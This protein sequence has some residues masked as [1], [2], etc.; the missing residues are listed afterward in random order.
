M[1]KLSVLI[2]LVLALGLIY[3]CGEKK[4]EAAA[5]K[6]VET[7]MVKDVVCNMDVDPSKSTVTAEYEGKKYYF[8]AEDCKVKFEANPAQ[9]VMASEGEHDHD[10][11]EGA[12]HK[13]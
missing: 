13:H 12:D 7:K 3:G 9:Y 10:H 2:I 8:C 5:D 11:S 6:P 1:R 4:E